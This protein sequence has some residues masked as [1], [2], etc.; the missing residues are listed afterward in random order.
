MAS[1]SNK[2][3]NIKYHNQ[4]LILSM[5]RKAES[6]SIAEI[7]T[8]INLSNTT[9]TKVVNCFEKKGLVAANGKGSSTGVGGKKPGIF[10]FN[11]AH[12]SVIAVTVGHSALSCAIM[13]LKCNLYSH[14]AQPCDY[15]VSYAEAVKMMA[16]MICAPMDD[17]GLEGG[18]ILSIVVGC[19][20]IIDSHNGIIRYPMHHNWERNLPLREDLAKLLPFPAN[21]CIDNNS[22]LAGYATLLADQA[23]YR[24][25]AVINNTHR[26]AGGSI[27]ENRALVHGAN[28]FVGEFG[29]MIIDP[30][31]SV[32]CACGNYG[33]FGA[34]VAG[35]TLIEETYRKVP[36]YRQ[37]VLAP[38]CRDETLTPE[39][40][41]AASN[42]GD[43]LACALMDTVIQCFA[44]LIH[45]TVILRDPEKIV[46]QG[47]YEGAGDYFLSNLR[48]KVNAMPFYKVE[49]RL[50]I[51]LSPV[52][53]GNVN[54]IG[55]GFYAVE[56]YMDTNSLYD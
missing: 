36:T 55:A 24:T 39:D 3:K 33:C 23:D 7:G 56:R 17:L 14:S 30:G 38:K 45:N 9:V 16:D 44:V 34:L 20:G 21:I 27:L 6:L 52:A 46:I 5:F 32:K 10:S 15:R 19:E 12:S 43:E 49:H 26:S 48:K 22:R 35:T 2:P 40:I 37:S 42:A 54:L 29:H 8:A 28:G 51:V 13:D 1:Q 41:F 47:M 31:S 53:P 50:P 25:L 11:A 18:K 4:K